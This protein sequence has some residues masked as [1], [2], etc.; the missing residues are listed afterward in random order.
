MGSQSA[1]IAGTAARRRWQNQPEPSSPT[2]IN[3]L[4]VDMIPLA[5]TLMFSNTT[6]G[7]MSTLLR[8]ALAA[9]LA[10]VSVTTFSAAAADVQYKLIKEVPIG[11]GGGWDYL[12]V[13]PSGHRLYVS[14][15][16]KVVV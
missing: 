2:C 9:I 3:D 13:D 14:H 6:K 8:S 12:H 5:S 15:G 4:C 10:I 1:R 16:T 11:G 7:P